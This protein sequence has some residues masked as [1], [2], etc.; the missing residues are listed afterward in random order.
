M[1]QG[2]RIMVQTPGEFMDKGVR[3]ILVRTP[4]G[5][6]GQRGLDNGLDPCK[7]LWTKGSG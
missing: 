5:V 3:I 6:Y 1:E 7:S 4:G 2:V